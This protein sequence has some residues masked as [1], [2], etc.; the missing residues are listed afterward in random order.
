MWRVALTLM[1]I[2][3]LTRPAAAQWYPGWDGYSDWPYYR[4]RPYY[5]NRGYW[6]QPR[7][8]PYYD[9]YDR[10]APDQGWGN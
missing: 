10:Y 5:D 2:A 9:G 6:D 1:A 3:S 7:R 4:S 8:D